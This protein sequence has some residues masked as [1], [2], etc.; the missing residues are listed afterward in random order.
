MP[1]LF[2]LVIFVR[3]YHEESVTRVG[4]YQKMAQCQQQGAL[5]SAGR[6]DDWFSFKCVPVNG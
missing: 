6:S 4:V 2:A 5:L 1:I 3:G